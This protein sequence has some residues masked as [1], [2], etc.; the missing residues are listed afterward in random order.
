MIF[1]CDFL[2]FVI[3]KFMF[4]LLDNFFEN[5]PIFNCFESSVIS[6]LGLTL[7]IPP[8]LGVLG[9]FDTTWILVPDKFQES[10]IFLNYGFES[11][12]G[13]NMLIFPIVLVNS[14]MK[15]ASSSLFL[16][17]VQCFCWM[18]SSVMEMLTIKG[19]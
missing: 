12:S 19:V 15:F 2:N 7:L 9:N 14:E 13:I 18:N 4:S 3:E 17:I 8:Y 11:L 16:I 10:R 1:W 5:F 6:Q